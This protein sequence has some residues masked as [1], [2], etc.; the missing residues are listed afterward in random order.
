M[1]RLD[2]REKGSLLMGWFVSFCLILCGVPFSFF[3]LRL[4]CSSISP[5]LI[6]C[7]PLF[8]YLFFLRFS[9][10]SFVFLSC[11]FVLFL[12][13][14]SVYILQNDIPC[15]LFFIYFL[16]VVSFHLPSLHPILISL[17]SFLTCRPSQVSEVMDAE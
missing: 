1:L 10:S 11:L 3:F 7:G 13:F 12:V 14:L 9:V 6:F 5:F 2:I 4:F 15:V 16:L 17:L 8:C